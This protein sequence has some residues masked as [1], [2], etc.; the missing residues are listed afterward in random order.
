MLTVHRLPRGFHPPLVTAAVTWV[1]LPLA[2]LLQVV[3]HASIACAMHQQVTAA[4]GYHLAL[5]QRLCL[6]IAWPFPL[7][8]TLLLLVCSPYVLPDATGYHEAHRLRLCLTNVG[9][10]ICSS[11]LVCGYYWLLRKTMSSI[12][13]AELPHDQLLPAEAAVHVVHASAA[14][15]YCDVSVLLVELPPWSN[16]LHCQ[17][18]RF[19]S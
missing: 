1:E 4:M 11:C 12:L 7:I 13:L 19:N 2:A 14:G 10:A 6:S 3:L 17:P 16:I 5:S 15:R 9:I 18:D 8:C